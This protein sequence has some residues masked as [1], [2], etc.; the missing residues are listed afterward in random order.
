MEVVEVKL[1]Q[2]GSCARSSQLRYL[3][4]WPVMCP[5]QMD[6]AEQPL[7]PQH[8]RISSVFKCDF[9]TPFVLCGLPGVGEAFMEVL[10]G[11]CSREG[12]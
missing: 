1:L 8:M 2:L 6:C 12:V 4:P 5:E 3:S 10:Q 7:T 9:F 11:S